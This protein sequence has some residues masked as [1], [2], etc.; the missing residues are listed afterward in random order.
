MQILVAERQQPNYFLAPDVVD[1]ELVVLQAT[2][3]HDFRVPLVWLTDEMHWPLIDRYVSVWDVA[4]LDALVEGKQSS[5]EASLH[6]KADVVRTCSLLEY[7]R[8]DLDGRPDSE[9]WRMDVI[10]DQAEADIDVRDL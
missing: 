6:I 8:R 4:E 2:L 10:M 9:D 7:E 1:D 3:N 5:V